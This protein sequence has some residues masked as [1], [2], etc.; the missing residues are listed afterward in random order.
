[1]NAEIETPAEMTGTDVTPAAPAANE[2][3]TPPTGATATETK[4]T[5]QGADSQAKATDGGDRPK[6]EV[7]E[8][9]LRDLKRM[10]FGLLPKAEAKSARLESEIAELKAQLAGSGKSPAQVSPEQRSGPSDDPL[11]HPAVAMLQRT[12]DDEGRT[13]VDFHGT[14]LTPEAVIAMHDAFATPSQK[15]QEQIEKLQG[16]ITSRRDNESAAQEAAKVRAFEDGITENIKSTID[17][18]VPAAFP[19]LTEKQQKAISKRIFADAQ[20][21]FSNLFDEAR[22]N[23]ELSRETLPGIARRS[24]EQAFEEGNEFISTLYEGRQ[25]EHNAQYKQNYPAKTGGTPG[26]PRTKLPT[27][28]ISR[29]QMAREVAARLTAEAQ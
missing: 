16:E 8:T 3:Q 21:N 9:K 7:P 19:N 11:N 5:Q 15:L 27:D 6:F 20:D 10:A 14:L 28:R 25:R 23:N 24:I 17:E 1:M 18:M 22:E 2:S 13:L 26:V 29:E 12:Y 4:P